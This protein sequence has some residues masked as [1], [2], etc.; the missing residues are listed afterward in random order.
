MNERV[1]GSIY[2]MQSG[3][4]IKLRVGKVWRE[5]DRAFKIDNRLVEPTEVFKTLGQIVE[6]NRRIFIQ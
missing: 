2:K 3:P 5:R 4:I 1:L 6:S